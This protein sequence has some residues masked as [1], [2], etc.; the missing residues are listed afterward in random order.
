[1]NQNKEDLEVIPILEFQN[2]F[3]FYMEKIEKE[4][5]SIIIE[6]LN[7]NQAVMVPADDEILKIHTEHNDAC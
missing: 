7:G 6:D 3:D 2:K 5:V 1:M 4:K